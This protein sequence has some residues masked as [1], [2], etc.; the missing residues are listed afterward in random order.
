M[1]RP[2]A[3]AGTFYPH[4]PE[5]LRRMIDALLGNAA[6][7]R[8][9]STLPRERKGP[10]G[11]MGGASAEGANAPDR[12]RRPQKTS[13]IACIV[14]HAGYV[15]SGAVA[16]QTLASVALPEVCIIICPN[17]TGWGPDASIMTQGTWSTPFG[18]V[19]VCEDL[20]RALLKKSAHLEGDDTAHAQEHAIEVQLP[21]IQA[22]RGKPFSI[23]PIVLAS[24]PNLVY[25]DIAS[26]V[27]L[28]VRETKAPTLVIA[29]TDLT[30]YEPQ[31]QANRKD[32]IA[33]EAML[34]R[35]DEG[36]VRQVGEHAISMCGV[37]PAATV[38]CAA[39]LL[40]ATQ[41]RLI[42]YQTSGDVTRDYSAVVGY[43]G[44]TLR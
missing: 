6:G 40:G 32:K 20:A 25:K 42:A 5:T 19:P 10:H 27:A 2:A 8:G 13:A 16:A 44:L 33:I 31:Q 26:A 24:V 36:L 4:R 12:T 1:N 7:G 41:S 15:Y 34:G 35:D 28:A 43:A 39:K 17:H 37:L 22:L 30:H 14:P 11:G 21:L 3:F 23:V 38:I 9:G 18:D 29:S